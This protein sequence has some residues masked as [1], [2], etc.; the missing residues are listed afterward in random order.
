MD[1]IRTVALALHAQMVQDGEEI[2]TNE[3]DR[4]PDI[5]LTPDGEI[6]DHLE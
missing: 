2:P 5:L 6:A 3:W 4:L 1:G